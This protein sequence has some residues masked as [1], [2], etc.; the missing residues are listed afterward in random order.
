MN[1]RHTILKI[2]AVSL[3]CISGV[4]EAYSQIS[5]QFGIEIIPRFYTPAR[6]GMTLGRND[7]KDL[8]APT[9]VDPDNGVAGPYNLGFS[10]DYNGQLYSQYYICVN[11]WITF[12]QQGAFI[13]YNPGSLFNNMR[14]NLTLAPYF[15]DHYLRT[16]GIDIS[17]PQGRTYRPSEVRIESKP[18]A[19]LGGVQT[20]PDT[21]VIEWNQL[22]INYRFDPTDPNA[23]ANPTQQPQATSVG[24]FQCWIIQAP[25]DP[26]V[27]PKNSKQGDIEFHYGA[28]GS[29]GIVKVSGASVGIED[30]PYQFGG[31]TTF[32]NAVAYRE[33]G[34]LDSAMFSRRLST[35]TWPPSGNPGMVFRFSG[36]KVRGQGVWGDGDAD[37]SQSDPRTPDFS[38]EGQ[39]LYVSFKDV[40]RIL[41]HAAF[42]QGPDPNWDYTF[43]QNGYHGDVNHDGRFF[44]SSS[45]WDGSGDSVINGRI[46]KYIKYERTKTDNYNLPISYD[47]TFERYLFDADEMD[48]A[49]IMLYLAAKLP[50]LPW[51]PDTL[52]PF[53]GKINPIEAASDVNFITGVRSGNQIEIP[54]KLNG[55]LDGSFGMKFEV[56]N[57][58]KV[59]G[60]NP[61][62]KTKA[63]LVQGAINGNSVAIAA[64]GKIS[65]D[66]VIAT[67]IVELPE[68]EDLVLSNTRVNGVN[69]GLRKIN[70]TGSQELKL[71]VTPNP[72]NVNNIAKI[73]YSVPTNSNVK[74]EIFDNKGKLVNT[75]LEETQKSGSYQLD[76]NCKYQN[77]NQVEA[78]NYYC[79]INSDGVSQ[80]FTIQVVK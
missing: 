80:T 16:F 79:R 33:T 20:L 44:Y 54:I 4:T 67:L 50:V 45:N 27:N 2:F 34:F 43:G 38:C 57:G 25:L 47:P 66:E 15:G 1:L 21:V 40:I 64:A 42:G 30:D 8:Y 71:S 22:N 39:R 53:T 46:F 5:G 68:N 24:T 17:D 37:V 55:H 73:N 62:E 6:G 61:V 18:S 13:T 60:I 59:V 56:A 51:L 9:V 26:A 58:A 48:A 23:P 49:L 78:G 76:W 12:A 19:R 11:G 10:F 31:F 41:R 7:F 52:P 74:I 65:K 32:L 70:V 69:G 63:G 3:L 28:L 29:A 72:M 36:R 77:G 14:P 35:G 75:V